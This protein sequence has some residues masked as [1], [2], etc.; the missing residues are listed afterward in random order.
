MIKNIDGVKFWETAQG[1]L[2]PETAVKPVDQ[3]R[4]QLVL[5]IVEDVLRE[6]EKLIA[7]KHKAMSDIKTF[8]QL[9][10][11]KYK[12]K[13]GSV[14]GNMT[15]TSYDGKYKVTLTIQ[16]SFGFNERIEAAKALIYDCV[17]DWSRGAN[18]N[19]LAVVDSAFRLTNGRL[20]VKS[21]LALKKIHVNDDTGRWEEAMSAIDDALEVRSSKPCLRI[22]ARDINGKY[23]LV[24]MD[25]T[26]IA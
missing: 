19:L 12:V 1:G 24:N 14:K 10:I 16:E 5:G 23:Q 22:Y 26:D 17:N 3:L 21:V 2:I 4:D 7:L 8:V 18:S 15:F 25:F 20:D 6:Q 13:S 9:S 11:E